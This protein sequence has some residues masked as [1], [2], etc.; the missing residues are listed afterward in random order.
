MFIFS[1]DENGNTTLDA[2]IMDGYVC[3]KNI[4]LREQ[5]KGAGQNISD[6]P[7]QCLQAY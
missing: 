7:K 1:P 5:L 4:P 2:M 3:L 6:L